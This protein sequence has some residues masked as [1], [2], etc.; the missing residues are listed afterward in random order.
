MGHRAFLPSVRSSLLPY[1]LRPIKP[2]LA[3]VMPLVMVLPVVMAVVVVVL[4][5]EVLVKA[6][7]SE[8]DG[9]NAKAGKSITEAVE[10]A[11]PASVAPGLAVVLSRVVSYFFCEAERSGEKRRRETHFL[12]QGS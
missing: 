3:L 7:G 1:Q 4:Q 8:G 12:S 6:V 2:S 10:P 9:G 5:E 11:E